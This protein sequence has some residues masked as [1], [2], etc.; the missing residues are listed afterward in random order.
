VAQYIAR[1]F[2]AFIPTLLVVSFLIFFMVE[3]VPG[4]PA[5]TMLGPEATGEQ[6]EAVREQMGLNEPLHVRLVNWYADALRGDLGRSFFLNQPVAEALVSRLP[7]TFSLTI[8]ALAFSLIFGIGAGVIASIRQGK[9]TDWGIMLLAI[10]GLSIPIFWLAL[11]MIWLFSVRLGWFPTGGYVAFTES[12]T[13][14][15][16]HL[17]MPAIALGLVHMAVIARM[18]RSSMLEVL[19]QDYVRSARAKGLREWVVIARHAFRNALIPIVTIVGISAGE[20]L[21]GSV[22]TETVFNLPGVGRLIVDAVRRRDYPLVQGG[23]LIITVSYLII[24]LLVDLL[25]AWINPRIRY[26]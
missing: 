19:R 5:A 6:L 3:L 26:Q 11:N 22:I 17:L 18:T 10:L 4:D 13:G 23:I 1:R 8:M 2:L 7:V 9:F 14:F 16:R 25:Y 12:P 15:F 24:N 20:M 21:A